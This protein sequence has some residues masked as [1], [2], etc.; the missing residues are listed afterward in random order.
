[1]GKD[2]FTNRETQSLNANMNASSERISEL[3][4]MSGLTDREIAEQM[5]ISV[6]CVNLWRHGKRF[7]EYGNL[8]FLSRILGVTV[9]D[10]FVA[11]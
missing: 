9:D 7:P 5:N 6:Q 4:K 8:Y 2:F 1:M 11:V 10:F 3:I